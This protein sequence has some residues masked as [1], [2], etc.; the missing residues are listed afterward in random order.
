MRRQGRGAYLLATAL[1]IAVGLGIRKFLPNAISKDPG[2]ILYATMIYWIVRAIRPASTLRT[3]ALAATIFCFAI[4]FL[5]LWHLGWLDRFR[6]TTAG[7][8][9]FGAVFSVSNLVCYVIGAGIGLAIDRYLLARL[10]AE[11]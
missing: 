8:L 7:H 10:Q 9:I 1:T 3:A 6:A 11:A 5:K 4:E 2:D